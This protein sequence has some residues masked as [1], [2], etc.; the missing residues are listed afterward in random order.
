M[1]RNQRKKSRDK[2]RVVRTGASRASAATGNVHRHDP[3]PDMSI[4]Q[5]LPHSA[6]NKVDLDFAGR[7][8]A[9]ARSG[10]GPC[11]TSLM[12]KIVQRHRATLA[13]LAGAVY[14]LE[15][16]AGAQHS[17][18]VS[19]AESGDGTAAFS[20]VVQMDETQAAELLDDALTHWAAGG[21]GPDAFQFLDLK[22]DLDPQGSANEWGDGTRPGSS[23]VGKDGL[24]SD[25]DGVPA[26]AVM[27]ATTHMPDG[28]PLPMLILE[29]ETAGAGLADLRRR[30]DWHA[31]DGSQL[32]EPDFNWRL[33]VDIATRS[34]ECLAQIDPDG[35]DVL[36]HLW[37]AN[38]TVPLPEP[39]WDLL[40]RAQHVLVAG[41][42]KD[43]EDQDAFQR[44]ADTGELLA[45]V[46]HVRFM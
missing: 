34:L 35:Y 9:A 11:Q 37:D 15:L 30:T 27:L 43:G 16:N 41:P 13:A 42:V 12:S 21:A 31:W 45:V 19:A 25:P 40:D 22:T 20:A 33:R 6:G 38:E 17:A 7:L 23:P 24:P 26:Y 14:G 2:A 29:C 3:V 44:A 36:P 5:G 8:V 10:C 32:S 46:A 18:R 39:F 1:V 4:L 28:R